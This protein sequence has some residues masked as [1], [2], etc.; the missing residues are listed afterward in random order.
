LT[1]ILE[2][3]SIPSASITSNTFLVAGAKMTPSAP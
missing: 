3:Y 1:Y 2:A